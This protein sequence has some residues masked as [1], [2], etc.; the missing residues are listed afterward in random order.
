[1]RA[2]GVHGQA[3]RVRR[4]QDPAANHRGRK[5]SEQLGEPGSSHVTE[6]SARMHGRTVGGCFN[7]VVLGQS[8]WSE[9]SRD[10]E[11]AGG[12]Q[13]LD[14]A[15]PSVRTP[16]AALAEHDG[17]ALASGG[18]DHVGLDRRNSASQKNGDV[19]VTAVL[20]QRRRGRRQPGT[21][22]DVAASSRRIGAA[23]RRRGRC[24]RASEAGRT[25]W[26]CAPTQAVDAPPGRWRGPP[27]HFGVAP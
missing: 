10:V 21:A 15:A 3:N 5:R 17:V 26:P 6:R 14:G 8:S 16:S 24:C 7:L 22:R 2:L 11:P 1:M 9:M 19:A 23:P 20:A 25:G 27:H 4:R 13:L 12:A 18:L